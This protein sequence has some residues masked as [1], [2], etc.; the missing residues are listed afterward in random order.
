MRSLRG[1]AHSAQAETSRLQGRL[2][3]MGQTLTLKSVRRTHETE[4][5]INPKLFFMADSDRVV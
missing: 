2:R 3:E 1:E 5:P 4:A